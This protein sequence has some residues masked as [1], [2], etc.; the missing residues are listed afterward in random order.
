MD[1]PRFLKD[2]LYPRSQIGA[3]LA[4]QCLSEPKLQG[5]ARDRFLPPIKTGL[6]TSK[7]SSVFKDCVLKK[8][9]AVPT[10][11]ILALAA[12]PSTAQSKGQALGRGFWRDIALRH[13]E[14]FVAD[15]KLAH[16]RGAQ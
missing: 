3:G 9:E 12:D 16:S 6:A 14:H 4:I 11:Q 8:A 1:L 2:H 7:F 10:S 5:I 15:Q 13:A